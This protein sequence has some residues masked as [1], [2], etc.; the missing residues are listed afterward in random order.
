MEGEFPTRLLVPATNFTQVFPKIS[1][2]GIEQV[3][4]REKVDYTKQKVA[5]A[6]DLKDKLDSL[7]INKLDNTLYSLEIK[8]MTRQ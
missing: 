3:F 5:E 8:A 2:Q 6:T 4:D 1:Y 7:K